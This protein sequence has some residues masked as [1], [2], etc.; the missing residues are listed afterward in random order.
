M[1]DFISLVSFLFRIFSLFKRIH[2]NVMGCVCVCPENTVSLYLSIASKTHSLPPS[3]MIPEP[4][5]EG[6]DPMSHLELSI[7]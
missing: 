7:L 2:F 5:E 3:T 4:W 6:C 1:I